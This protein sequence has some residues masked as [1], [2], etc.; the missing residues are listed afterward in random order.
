MEYNE[1]KKMM[2]TIYN[3]IKELK[4]MGWRNEDIVNGVLDTVITCFFWNYETDMP[5]CNYDQ[6]ELAI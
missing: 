5:T 6:M 1:F 3:E 4:N 2:D